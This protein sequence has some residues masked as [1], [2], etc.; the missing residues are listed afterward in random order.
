MWTFDMKT[1]SWELLGEL[2]PDFVNRTRIRGFVQNKDY[3]I[4]T[5]NNK[6][7]MVQLDANKY[8]TYTSAAYWNISRVIPSFDR[9]YLLVA[10][11]NSN[12]SN[13]KVVTIKKLK[14]MLIGV[15]KENFLYRPISK[16]NLFMAF[17]HSQYHSLFLVVLHQ[18]NHQNSLV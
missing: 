1:K 5:Y 7:T 3:S 4:F 13:R 2:S 6:L 14:E 9:K 18:K 8:F 17:D 11:H 16:F 10:R 12:V 15:P